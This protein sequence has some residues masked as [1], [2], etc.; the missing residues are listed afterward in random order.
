MPAIRKVDMA[1]SVICVLI[2]PKG[3]GFRSGLFLV[4]FQCSRQEQIILTRFWSGHLQTL[5][6]KD[7]NKVLPTCV[8]CSACQASPEHILDC[9]GLTKHDLYEGLIMV[10]EFLRVNEI[11]V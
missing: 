7:E 4:P 10:L 6:F 5:T 8:W 9:L 2:R 11:M 3:M 1:G